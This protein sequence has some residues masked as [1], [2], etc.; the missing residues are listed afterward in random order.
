MGVCKEEI[1]GE[2]MSK[3]IDPEKEP[4]PAG[5]VPTVITGGKQPPSE[6]EC[7]LRRLHPGT[8]FITSY[9]TAYYGEVYEL[10]WK[11]DKYFLLTQTLGEDITRD[12]YVL[13]ERFSNE[14]PEYEILCINPPPEEEKENE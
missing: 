13:P 3:N 14:H 7:W 9:A 1:K 2:T 8:V 12:V 6:F 5:W 10:L 4:V 11:G